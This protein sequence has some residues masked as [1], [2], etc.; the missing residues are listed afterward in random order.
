MEIEVFVSE[1]SRIMNAFPWLKRIK[2]GR[3]ETRAWIRM[4]LNNDFVDVFYNSEMGTTSYAFIESGERVF[5]ANNMRIG[6]HWHPYDDVP[7][8]ELSKPVT[9]EEFLKALENE[10]RERNKI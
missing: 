9:I 1:V 10:L 7:K 2:T 5:A 6:W 3:S 4:W 8:H